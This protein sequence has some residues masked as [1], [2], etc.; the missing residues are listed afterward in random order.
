MADKIQC[1][2]MGKYVYEFADQGIIRSID[3][4][5]IYEYAPGYNGYNSF[6]GG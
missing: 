3:Y 5:W 4:D 2:S 6:F 1:N